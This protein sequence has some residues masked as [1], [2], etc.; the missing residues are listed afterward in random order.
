MI[1]LSS[2]ATH[3]FWEIPVLFEDEHLL[4]VDKP[5][6]LLVSPDRYD[7]NRP[8]LMKLLHAGI[9]QGK[10]WAK[11]RNLS[12]LMNAHR[13]DFQT[14]GVILL[15]KDK[16][17]LI[18]LA[19]QF[20]SEK[21]H[22]KY[23]ALVLDRGVIT[24]NTFETDAKIA[25]NELRLGLMR[26]DP[27]NGKRSKTEFTVRE[28]LG[29]FVLLECRPITGRSHQIRVHLK[30]LRLPI[31]GDEDYGGHPLLLSSLKSAYRLKPGKT[32]RPLIARV[33]LHAE[34]LTVT[35]PITKADVKITA[36]W[37]RDLTVAVKYLRRYN[38][39]LA[40]ADSTD[41]DPA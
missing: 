18:D 40:T 4:A 5:A 37:P 12:Y 28:R 27:K 32:E 29:R 7:P 30:H 31:V 41:S 26:I 19:T 33:A 8:N 6:G 39:G 34:E 13:L 10:P 20:G 11:Q 15:A 22:K 25:P 16:S 23:I 38:T 1:K 3:E 35:H 14:S 17:V 2:P 21:P 24:A 9:E 36:P